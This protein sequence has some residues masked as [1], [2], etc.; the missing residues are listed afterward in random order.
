MAHPNTLNTTKTLNER[1]NSP[2]SPL[3]LRLNQKH[4]GKFTDDQALIMM[5]LGEYQGSAK[6]LARALGV[7]EQ[8]LVKWLENEPL[9]MPNDIEAKLHKITGIMRCYD[10]AS[11]IFT[12]GGLSSML[13]WQ[14]LIDYLAEEVIQATDE[15]FEPHGELMDDTQILCEAVLQIFLALGIC[16]PTPFPSELIVEEQED[17]AAYFARNESNLLLSLL[18][19][20]FHTVNSL[21]IYYQLLLDEAFCNTWWEFEDSQAGQ[22]YYHLLDLAF[23]KAIRDFPETFAPQTKRIYSRDRSNYRAWFYRSS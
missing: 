14:K 16:I 22:T 5:A 11:L 9:L 1:L 4:G 3:T 13:E 7:N 19:K 6:N 18:V 20:A 12:V 10:S 8:Q 2:I 15:R 21:S 17:Y 23:S